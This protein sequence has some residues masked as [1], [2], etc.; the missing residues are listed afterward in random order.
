[1]SALTDEQ[2]RAIRITQAN[3]ITLQSARIVTL[4]IELREALARIRRLETPQ[5]SDKA[6]KEARC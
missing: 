5:P 4:E 3:L 1:M 6:I 2:E